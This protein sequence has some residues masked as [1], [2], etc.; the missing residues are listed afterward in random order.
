MQ[1]N[2]N[3]IFEQLR[4]QQPILPDNP[5]AYKLLEASY[6]TIKLI[7]QLNQSSDPVQIRRLL[8]EIL[9][10]P[11][12]DSINIFPPLYINSGRNL[13]IGKNVFINFGCTFLALGGI[14]IEENVLIAPNVCILSEGHPLLPIE[15]HTLVLNPVYI[16]KNAWIGAGVTILPGVTIGEN[17]VIAAGAVVNKDVPDDTVV[18]GIPATIIKSVNIT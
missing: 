7:N 16:K 17:A 10:K 3:D 11:I 13:S 6:A 14:T 8:A 2:Q 18:A 12:A 9:E 4:A 1:H 15:R 5:E